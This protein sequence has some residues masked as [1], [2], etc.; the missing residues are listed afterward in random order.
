MGGHQ[1]YSIEFGGYSIPL[2]R[3]SPY[4]EWFVEAFEINKFIQNDMGEP[5]TKRIIKGGLALAENFSLKV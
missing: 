5:A 2:S 1:P 4:A 3:L